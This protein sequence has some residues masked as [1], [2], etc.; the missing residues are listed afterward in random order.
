MTM[1]LRRARRELILAGSVALCGALLAA[2]VA[3]DDGSETVSAG[4]VERAVFDVSAFAQEGQLVDWGQVLAASDDVHWTVLLPDTDG[5]ELATDEGVTPSGVEWTRVT[6]SHPSGVEWTR[7]RA[8]DLDGSSWSNTSS[9]DPTG[10]AWTF[11]TFQRADGATWA[12]SRFLD[13]NGRSWSR[14]APGN[15]L[16]GV[17]WT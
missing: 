14:S 1:M 7:L 10:V 2:P 4:S 3:A 17:E 12:Q 5:F 13:G 11:T 8:S 15:D 9:T 6:A 16:D